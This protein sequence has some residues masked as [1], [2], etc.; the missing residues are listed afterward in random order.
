MSHKMY[1]LAEVF[2][3]IRKIKLPFTRDQFILLMAAVNE[4]FLGLDIYLAHSISG[5]IVPREWIP[6]IFGPAA[7]V[8]LLAAGLLALKRRKAAQI[9]ATVVLAASIVVGLLGAYFHLV[10]GILPTAPAGQKINLSLLVWAPPVIGP[11]MF[12]LIGL[13]GISA[14]WQE[15][16]VDSGRLRLLGERTLKLPYSKTRAYFLI[17]SLGTMATLISSVLDHARTPFT[18]PW[19]WLPTLTGVF[20]AVVAFL[21]AVYDD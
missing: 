19:L 4:L 12:S 18:N 7:G 10:R 5:T 20:A 11:L 13:L 8:L 16:P 9:L 3:A 2:P 1:Y 21:L 17:V 15:A 14:A 6:I